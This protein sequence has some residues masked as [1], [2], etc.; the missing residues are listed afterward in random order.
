L[1]VLIIQPS[2]A[3]YG[4]AEMVVVKLANYLSGKG[5][6]NEILTM[7]ISKEVKSQL[8]GTRVTALRGSISKK[9]GASNLFDFAYGIVQMW[10]YVRRNGHRYDVIN[11]HNFPA[12]Y[13]LFPST[14][15]SVWMCNEPPI[16]LYLTRYGFPM[17]VIQKML[18][19][20]DRLVV[21]R[22]VGC[23]VVSDEF[24][25]S[26]FERIYGERPHI[27]NYG[28]DCAAFSGG[29]GSRAEKMF[30]LQ[31]R[32]VL[33]Q[34]GTLTQLK[35]QMES[36][37]VVEKLK[38]RIPGIKLVLAGLGEE[39]YQGMLKSYVKEKK[40]DDYVT[41]TGHV[42]RD[43]VRD[44]YNACDVALFPV[45][46]QGGWLSP[47]EALCAGAPI[48]VS[49][50]LTCSGIIEKNRLGA[51]TNDFPREV[52]KFYGS[53]K[54]CKKAAK[55]GGE[56]VRKNLTWNSFC[57]KMLALFREAQK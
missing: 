19:G 41:F 24:D 43:V 14:R 51:V 33:V 10:A 42:P 38:G 47:F 12:E 8:K 55:N 48:I 36:V 5:V 4:G 11:P 18:V 26:R 31:G 37:R 45:K 53:R 29:D 40:L 30:D 3:F 46:S 27:A 13:A 25:A 34:V 17:S 21:R 54:E 56:W 28:V 39:P 57:E 20:I 49:R 2:M 35:N 1:K 22:S 52:M 15:N 6:E 44:L 23:S 9:K 32:F 16:Q 7:R 50:T